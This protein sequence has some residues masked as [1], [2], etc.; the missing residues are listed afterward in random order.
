M[1]DQCVIYTRFSP[2]RNSDE[3]ESCETQAAQCGRYAAEQG[4]YI[5]A[6]TEDKAKSGKDANR[7]GLAKAISM[8]GKGSILLVYKRDRIARDV[9]LAELTRRQVK[10]A[11]ASIVAVSGDIEGD[12][13]DPTVLFVRQIMDAVAELERKQIS[14]RTKDAMHQHQRAGKKMS[15]IPPFG[16]MI[17]PT[18]PDRLV[19]NSSEAPAVARIMEL[20]KEGNKPYMIARIMDNCMPEFRRGK[21]WR[22][23]TIKK[24]IERY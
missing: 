23:R 1:K 3:S 10:Q 2:R 21:A 11:G 22:P 13:N 15:S 4:W 24:V 18:N 9:M 5:V 19:P 8:L 16:T 12:E 14:Q 17:D 20:Y 6:V 7:P